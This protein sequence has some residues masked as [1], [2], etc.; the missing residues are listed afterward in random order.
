[1]LL[2]SHGEA[3]RVLPATPKTWS[4][5][6]RFRTRGG[7][8]VSACFTQGVPKFVEIESL[9]G[10]PLAI[11]HPWARAEHATEGHPPV[12]VRSGRDTRTIASPEAVLRFEP[13]AGE[14]LLLCEPGTL[15][16]VPRNR[17]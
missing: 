17:I 7:F 1:M 14:K 10:R 4:G 16:P 15:Q 12:V 11:Y 3:I 6:F 9:T 2:Q 13:R 8:L 5:L